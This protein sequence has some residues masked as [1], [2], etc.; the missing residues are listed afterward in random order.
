M[1]D[2]KPEVKLPYRVPVLRVFGTVA[3]ITETI[4]PAGTRKDGGPNNTKS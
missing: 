4:S 1:E 2:T 3:T